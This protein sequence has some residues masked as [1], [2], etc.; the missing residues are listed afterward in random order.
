MIQVM[1]IIALGNPLP[2]CRAWNPLWLGI[3][4]DSWLTSGGKLNVTKYIMVPI[5][6]HR[7]Q[8]REL[9]SLPHCICAVL[10]VQFFWVVRELLS[11]APEDV[12]SEDIQAHCVHVAMHFVDKITHIH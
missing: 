3:R 7:W 6:W 5:L 9:T 11:W 1:D 12:D 4:T 2:Y 8:Q 10:S